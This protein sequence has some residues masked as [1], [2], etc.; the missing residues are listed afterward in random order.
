MRTCIC[1]RMKMTSQEVASY[2][3]VCER[4]Y[5][6]SMAETVAKAP[7]PH[8]FAKIRPAHVSITERG[9]R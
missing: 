2:R 9:G 4:C 7:V 1:C 3:S 6:D 8:K 5:A